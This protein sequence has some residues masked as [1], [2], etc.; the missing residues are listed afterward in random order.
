[1]LSPGRLVT[2]AFSMLSIIAYTKPDWHNCSPN[3]YVFSLPPGA[4]ALVIAS[5]WVSD[6]RWAFI[7]HGGAF[8]WTDNVRFLMV[9]E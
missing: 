1:M 2:N 4:M 5:V 6:E 7:V 8:G 9:I 3:T